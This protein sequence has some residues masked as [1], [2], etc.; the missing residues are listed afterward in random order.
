MLSGKYNKFMTAREMAR[1]LGRRGGRARAARLSIDDKKR[2]AS[3]GG[4]ARATSFLMARRLMA[5]LRY[6]AM[7]AELRGRRV[8]VTR[9]DA[10]GGPLTGIYPGRQSQDALS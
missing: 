3:L 10:F 1:I 7:V 2:I 4:K 6:A 9:Q 8:A 5:N